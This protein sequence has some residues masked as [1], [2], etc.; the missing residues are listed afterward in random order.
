LEK[1]RILVFIGASY[2]SGLE[3][4]TLH[5]LKGLKGDGQDVRCIVNGWN[6]GVFRQKLDEA[7]IPWYQLK[8]GWIY[9]RKPM[10]T[11][12]SLW[13]WPGAYREC[14]R[15]LKEFDPEICYFSSFQT[16]MMIYPLMKGRNNVYNLQEPRERTRKHL[17]IYRLLNKRI[18]IFTTVSGKIVRMLQDLDLP[19]EKIRLIYNGVPALEEMPATP[20]GDVLRFGII[21][22]I[23]PWKGHDTLVDA[24]ERLVGHATARFVVKIFGNDQNEY[25]Q[26]IKAAIASKGL[27]NYFEWKG[28]VR[29]QAEIYREVDAVIV[30]SLSEEPCSLTILESMMRSKGLIVS[31]RGGNPE[32][33]HHNDS[34]LI[35]AAGNPADL[36]LCMQFYLKDRTQVEKM[37]AKAGQRARESFTD[38]RMTREY[39]TVFE[40]L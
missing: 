40:E 29:E 6:D 27:E 11:M 30:P 26:K 2:V 20:S 36:A 16:A 21:G 4:A 24:V 7:G 1:K 37:G 3:I 17:T 33:V 12:D 15:I 22:Q 38:T 25:A 23:V 18:K 8:I 31:D 34:G 10:W 19:A 13:H 28:F 39:F 35:F 32:L 5:L 9:L 14:K